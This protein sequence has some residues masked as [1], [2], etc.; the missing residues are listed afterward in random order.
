MFFWRRVAPQ[1]PEEGLKPTATPGYTRNFRDLND[2]VSRGKSFSGYERNPLYLNLKGKGF[3]EAAAL[4][5]VDYDDDSRAV[6]VIDWDQDGDL[7]MWIT[8]R[9]A[10]RVR[11]LKNNFPHSTASVAV[12]LIGNGTTT[13]RDA[14]GARLVLS[15]GSQPAQ[16]RTVRAGDGF[17]SQSTAWAHFGLGP[18]SGEFL[19]SVAWPAGATETF[20]G[21][22]PGARYTI[23]QGQGRLGD[24]VPASAAAPQLVP[25]AAS[26]APEPG[27]SGFWVVNQVPF[28]NL[29]CTDDKGATR[30][31]TEFLGKPVLVNLWATWCRPCLEELSVLAKHAQDLA[32]QGA[33]VLALNVDGLALDGSAPD[34]GEK[35]EEVLAR[36]G[37]QLPHGTARQENLAMIEILIEYLTARRAPPSIPTSFLVDAKGNVAAVYLGPI[38]WEQLS[39]D[40]ALLNSP[41]AAQLKRASPRAGRWFAD[42]L[43]INRESYLGDYATLFATNGFPEESQRLYALAKPRTGEQTAQEYYNQAKSA[44]QQGLT[45]QA[46]ELYRKSIGLDP[47]YGQA[48]TGLGAMLLLQK[49]MDEAQPLFEK[50]LSIDPN[51]ATALVNLAMIDQARGKAESALQRLRQ[52]IARNPE[53]AEAQ[54]NLGSLLA[55]TK[56][57]DEAIQH[58][59][60]AV[61]LNPKREVAHLNL[62][63]ALMETQQFGKAAEHYRS[64]L[65]LNPRIP[66]AHYGLGMV[67]AREQN[68]ADAVQSFRKSIEL[69]GSNSR[70]FTQL[71]LSLLALG[72]KP[73][74]AQALS[75]AIE[76]D[77]KNKNARRALQEN[78][79]TVP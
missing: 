68:H 69:G 48:L 44:A 70:T 67:Q 36:L 56:Q 37:Y 58:L 51:H 46:M 27:K 6:A 57:F 42:P 61:E 26:A 55:S 2:L 35:P 63:A 53:Y 7:D 18:E 22:K 75:R 49:R 12:R 17:L 78:G 13:N 32:A 23:T 16:M 24:P 54:L 29:S 15:G 39:G 71:G 60:K 19:L 4:L 66:F 28:P 21:L 33:T 5:G 76:L 74:A 34:S 25:V 45:E 43:N 41:P 11:L 52:V 14:I 79:L 65:Q 8:N 10:P 20:S 9:T 50:A 73:Q 31:T 3:S 30:T 62:A 72:E 77:P 47:N 64:A 59:T 40:L 38:S 1:I